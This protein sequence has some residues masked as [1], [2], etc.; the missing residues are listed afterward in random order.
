M[1]KKYNVFI[2]TISTFL[3]WN[4][5]EILSKYFVITEDHILLKALFACF[6]SYAT[7]KTFVFLIFFLGKRIALIK[8]LML[9]NEYLDGTWIGHYRGV[10]GN[11]RYFIE[12]IEQNLDS[13]KIRGKSFNED[14]ELNSTWNSEAVNVDGKSGT[15]TYTYSTSG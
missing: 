4:L 10:S 11:I 5:Y 2:I 15:L 6:F 13:I 8:K 7:Y 14:M 12:E 3:F 1:K 9:G